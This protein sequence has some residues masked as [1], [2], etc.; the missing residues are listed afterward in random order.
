M[1]VG[2]SPAY[3]SGAHHV[4]GD[5]GVVAHEEA[6]LALVAPVGVVLVAARAARHVAHDA[7]F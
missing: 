2:I 7:L 6:G 5:V 4:A 3:C 1:K